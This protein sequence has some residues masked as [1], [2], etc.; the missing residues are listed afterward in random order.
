MKPLYRRS[1]TRTSLPELPSEVRARVDEAAFA[2]QLTVASDAPAWATHSV[3]LGNR[4][5]PDIESD[6]YV[7]L[8]AADIVV[9]ISGAERGMHHLTLPLRDASIADDTVAGGVER[10]MTIT[11]LPGDHSSAGSCYVGLGP[12]PAAQECLDAVVAAVTAAKAR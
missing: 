5:D 8:G 10:G 12:E 7:V 6:T 11:G 9:V 4:V 3:N 1:T 2:N